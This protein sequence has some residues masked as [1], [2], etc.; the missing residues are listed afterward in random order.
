MSSSIPARRGMLLAVVVFA[1]A[2]SGAHASGLCH[3]LKRL[4]VHAES[5]FQQLRG[6]FDPRLRTW[7]ATYR[8]PGAYRCTIED[9]ERIAFYS[10]K[11]MHD[12]SSTSVSEAYTSTVDSITN[13]LDVSGSTQHEQGQGRYST[14]LG[15]SGARKS[16]VVEKNESGSGDYTLSVNVVPLALSEFPSQ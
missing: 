1:L 12:A 13:C 11:W 4:L 9:F 16:V 5:N 6:Y 2:A 3:P 10:C 8:M 14:R 7:V 15:I